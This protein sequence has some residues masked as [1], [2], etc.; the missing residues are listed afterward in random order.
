MHGGTIEARS[1]GDGRGSEFIV[2]LP[3]AGAAALAPGPEPSAEGL[4]AIRI[5]VV[6]DNED[7]ASSLGMLLE[8]LGAEVDVV[9][10]GPSALEAYAARIPR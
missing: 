9:H 1:E 7:A 10:D 3:L 6:D 5:L 8:E 2:R 4:P